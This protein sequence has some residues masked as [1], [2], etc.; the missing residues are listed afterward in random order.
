MNKKCSTRWRKFKRHSVDLFNFRLYNQNFYHFHFKFYRL[1]K[2][3]VCKHKIIHDSFDWIGRD[4]VSISFDALHLRPVDYS[5]RHNHPTK[6]QLPESSSEW[7]KR[8]IVSIK[9][10]FVF[11]MIT[12][13]NGINLCEIAEL[14]HFE[15][16][17]SLSTTFDSI[18]S[19]WN[20][21]IVCSA[22]RFYVSAI[23]MR[24]MV[25]CLAQTS[26]VTVLKTCGYVF[27]RTTIFDGPQSFHFKLNSTIDSIDK[28]HFK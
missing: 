10:K 18:L 17:I 26:H 1:N 24:R 22:L 15:F 3:I 2:S 4:S 25:V 27:V 8:I 13:I 21:L 19:P 9:W 23:S 20:R 28:I 12:E 16:K 7:Q 11:E 5:V 14:S 6:F